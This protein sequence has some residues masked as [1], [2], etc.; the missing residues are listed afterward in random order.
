[1]RFVKGAVGYYEKGEM[2]VFIDGLEYKKHVI[3]SYPADETILLFGHFWNPLLLLI[4][5]L[6]ALYICIKNKFKKRYL[7]II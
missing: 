7:Y 6:I 1:M 3:L 4:C 5:G 2:P